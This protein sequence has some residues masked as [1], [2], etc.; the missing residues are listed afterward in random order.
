[1]IYCCVLKMRQ[2]TY[3]LGLQFSKGNLRFCREKLKAASK[4]AAGA[5]PK[6]SIDTQTKQL[7]N[8]ARLMFDTVCTNFF[9]LPNKEQKVTGL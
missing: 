5:Q 8:L 4:F 1:M 9:K 2:S 3:L 7:K 6:R